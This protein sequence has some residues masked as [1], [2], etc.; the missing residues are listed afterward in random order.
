MALE[1]LSAADLLRIKQV[2]KMRSW[3]LVAVDWE[4][5]VN[6]AVSRTLSGN[7]RW[8][9]AVP[10]IAFLVQ[11]I[12]SIANEEW[13]DIGRHRPDT[14][15][16]TNPAPNSSDAEIN[17]I[18]PEREV[19]AANM[20]EEIETLFQ[21]DAEATAV[22]SGLAQ[23]LSPDEVRAEAGL[24]PTQYSSAQKRIRRCLARKFMEGNN[25]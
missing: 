17:Q 3:G 11:T 2:G 21:G 7:R 23:G 16:N 19:I 13:R 12:R 10:F 6:E 25:P 24:T 15:I 4:D 14:A 18:H 8:P 5:L 1:N 9:K 22:I 20:L